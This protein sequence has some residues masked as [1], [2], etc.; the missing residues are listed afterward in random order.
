M[1]LIISKKAKLLKKLWGELGTLDWCLC[2]LC[3]PMESEKGSLCCH[4]V[5]N[6]N[7]ILAGSNVNCISQH[8]EWLRYQH[9][10]AI[11]ICVSPESA[12]LISDHLSFLLPAFKFGFRCSHNGRPPVIWIISLYLSYQVYLVIINY[13]CDGFRISPW[14]AMDG[15]LLW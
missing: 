8:L 1:I 15:R 2:E 13:N 14:V 12:H 5:Q 6:L 4:S 11:I 9:S 7:C 10:R 3:E